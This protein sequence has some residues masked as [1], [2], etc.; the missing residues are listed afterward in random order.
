MRIKAIS[1]KQPW[2]NLIV[3]GQKS[4]E[5]RLWETSY[6]G[7]LLIVSSKKPRIE[8]AGCALA[9][10]DLVDCRRM[11]AADEHSAMCE[12]YDGA[13]AW[14]LR[15]VLP[16]APVPIRGQLGLYE[17]EIE[18]NPHDPKSPSNLFN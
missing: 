12:I 1:V 11:V 5:T 17:V 10:V 4:I 2:A 8:P 18:V 15:D 16:I 6:R 7:P 14:V 13:F 9:I 3:S